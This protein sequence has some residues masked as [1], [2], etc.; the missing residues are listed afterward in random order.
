M[1][2]SNSSI[3]KIK[4][5]KTKLKEKKAFKILKTIKNVVLVVF[6]ASLLCVLALTLISRVNGETP[7]VFGYT[8]YRV[9][10]ASMTPFLQVGDIILCRE[11]DPM[12]LQDGDI[13]TYNGTSGDLAGKRVTHRVVQEPYQ[14]AA[15]GQYYL[16]TKGDDNPIEDTPIRISQVTGKMQRKL[17]LLKHL[18]DFFITPWGLLT[19]LALIILAFFNEIINFGKALLGHGAEEE[20]E[21][22]QDVIER[23]RREDAEKANKSAE[24][25]DDKNK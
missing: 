12:T 20:P 4:S 24:Q 11:C 3:E 8:I 22:I 25:S 6:F 1:L 19:I 18:Y 17:G 16:V 7:S 2:K 14:N 5:I 9:S 13:I 15:D 10:S 23:I 21:D